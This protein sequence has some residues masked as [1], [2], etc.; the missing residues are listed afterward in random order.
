M[1]NHGCYSIVYNDT[2]GSNLVGQVVGNCM[3]VDSPNTIHGNFSICLPV[4]PA[5]NT[6]SIFSTY[7][8]AFIGGTST[9]MSSKGYELTMS[10]SDQLC[11]PSELTEL[12]LYCPILRKSNQADTLTV[13]TQGCAFNAMSDINMVIGNFSTAS[14]WYE[15]F[16]PLTA[17]DLL[18]VNKINDL[19]HTLRSTPV[20]S[21]LL[22]SQ[23]A[24]IISS[25]LLVNSTILGVDPYNFTINDFNFTGIVMG[26]GETPFEPGFASSA[27]AMGLG[28]LLPICLLGIALMI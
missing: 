21:T 14:G 12:G 20:N 24:S 17:T 11:V 25:A 7:D 5:I 2:A 28:K 16:Q 18:P 1:G 13:V 26:G 4:N 23:E 22:L 27:I 8:I 6:T 19:I 10:D 3:L 9:V 15:N